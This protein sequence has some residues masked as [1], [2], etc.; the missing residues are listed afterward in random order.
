MASSSYVIQQLIPALATAFARLRRTPGRNE[1]WVEDVLHAI[2]RAD[3]TRHERMRR[4][5]GFAERLGDLVGLSTEERAT[6]KLGL[7]FGELVDGQPARSRGTAGG[8]WLEYLLRNEDWL[9]AAFAVCEV[10]KSDTWEALE[11]KAA[12]VAKVTV[13]FDAATLERQE[14]PLQ[15]IQQLMSEVESPLAQEVIPMLWSEEGQE[16]CDHHFRRHPRG[17]KLEAAELRSSLEALRKLAPKRIPHETAIAPFQLAGS[18][19]PAVGEELK[20]QAAAHQPR[21]AA[22]WSSSPSSAGTNFDRRREALRARNPVGFQESAITSPPQPDHDYEGD[23]AEPAVTRTPASPVPGS[24][25]RN[26]DDLGGES[27][28]DSVK[29][30]EEPMEQTRTISPVPPGRRDA[31]DMMQKLQDVRLQLGQ[32]QRIAVDAEQ[33]LTGLA[34]QLDELAT[35]VADLDTI[36]KRWQGREGIERAA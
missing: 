21:T 8:A 31:L 7:F 25:H 16:L 5:I 24:P 33:L 36:V 34:P 18:A 9:G 27:P 11:S 32:I 10:I 12:A 28:F 29:R 23:H 35:W 26:G 17:Y 3:A 14:R 6:L 19:L 20:E 4:R 15:V 22:A 30:G 2:E 1:V 13:V